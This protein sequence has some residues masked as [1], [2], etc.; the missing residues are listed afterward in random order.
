MV[1]GVAFSPDGK[2][3]ASASAD[4]TI[5]LWDIETFNCIR[6]L[7]GSKDVVWSVAFTPDGEKLASCGYESTISCPV[8]Q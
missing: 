6:T 1:L 5:K 4:K 2:T 3:L 8:K 7:T